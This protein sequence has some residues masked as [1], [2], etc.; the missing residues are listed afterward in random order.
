MKTVVLPGKIESL[1]AIA[2]YARQAACLAELNE[3]ATYRLRLAVDEIA[4]NIITHGYG[5]MAGEGW[6]TLSAVL[7]ESRLLIQLEETGR[8]FD[9]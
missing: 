7:E 6:L 5:A 2:E 9:P 1:P 4:A 3:Q 8:H